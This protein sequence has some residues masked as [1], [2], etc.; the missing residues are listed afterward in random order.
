[1]FFADKFSA[2]LVLEWAS[3]TLATLMVALLTL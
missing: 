2:D 3:S 1:M